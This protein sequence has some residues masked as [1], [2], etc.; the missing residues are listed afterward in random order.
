MALSQRLDLRQSQTLV[1]TPQLQQAIKLLQLSN[2]E[3]TEYIESELE[4]NPILER[5][6]SETSTIS[7]AA[8][9]NLN[10]YEDA[11]SDE[12]TSERTMDELSDE[13]I[14][15]TLS[16]TGTGQLPENNDDPIDTDYENNWGS[17]GLDETAPNH[18]ENNIIGNNQ[19]ESGQ[20][21]NFEQSE[22]GIDQSARAMKSLREHLYEQ[23]GV[24]FSDPMQRLIGANL[25]E[26][27]DNTGYFI[28]EMSDIASS[29]AC[30]LEEIQKVF[31][32]LQQCDP[33]GVFAR[34]L[35][36]CLALQLKEKNRF[37][38]A[39]ETLL[40]H[41]DLLAKSDF[42]TLKK[43][44]QVDDEDM[45][46]MISD[47]RSLDP[48]PGL[49]FEATIQEGITPDILM[50]PGPDGEWILEINSEAL[51]RVLVNN[52]YVT[53]VAKNQLQK[54]EKDYLN[55]CIQSANW[56][57]RSLHQRAT[58]IL[59]VAAEIVRQQDEFF[60]FGVQYLRPLILRDIAEAIEMHESTVSRVTNNK[61]IATPRGMLELKYF[62][63]A[64]IASAAGGDA[65]SAEAV[66]SK[67]KTLIDEEPAN[68]VLSDDR[69]VEILREQG[70]NIARRTVAKYRDA[71][72]IPSSVQ[73]R[74]QKMM[75]I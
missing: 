63:T 32:E 72:R 31:F 58:T 12:V 56:L 43:L 62:F 21:T 38:P 2:A 57:V 64:A 48:K 61:Y 11:R 22:Y 29:L 4:K 55:E 65:L 39:M 5:D 16:D 25:I 74:R 59:K 66:R 24:D 35:S 23:L 40:E 30:G 44:C 9:D 60:R 1:M 50:R 3:L 49:A 27:V 75:P 36:E 6:E 47:I 69:L 52:T 37:D 53:K 20:K 19:G 33:P 42:S 18:F 15:D 54:S 41:L 45:Q 7:E 34:S 14:S 8:M 46:E 70:V 10:A 13:L 28:G 26:M 68:K 73:R 67:I 17:A 71:M 51:P